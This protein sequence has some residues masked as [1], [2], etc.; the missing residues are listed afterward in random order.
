LKYKK[1]STNQIIW[2]SLVF[3]LKKLN[4]SMKL[5][6]EFFFFKGFDVMSLNFYFFLLKKSV[7]FYYLFKNQNFFVDFFN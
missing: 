5:L 4:L 7:Q 6:I 3:Y 2:Y 1:T